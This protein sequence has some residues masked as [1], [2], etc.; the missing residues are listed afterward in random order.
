MI[1]RLLPALLLAALA[2]CAH[3][4]GL[5]LDAE[6]PYLSNLR[7]LTFSG[8][9]AEGYFGFA[10]RSFVYQRT[11]PDSG[12]IC[13]QIYSYDLETGRQRRISNGQGRTTCSYYLPGDTLV[14]YATTHFADP[15][16]P[17]RP[18]MSK[19]YVW[20]LYP[21]YDIVVADT[22]GRFVRRLT[23]SPGYDAEATVSPAGDRIVFTSTRT[24]DIELFSMNLDGSDVR[25]LTSSPGYDGG[26]FYSWDGKKIVFR[27]SMPTDSEMVAYRA[28]LAENLVRPSRMELFVMNADGSHRRQVTNNGAAN[29][30]PFW[31]P[32][33]RHII[34][35]SNVGDPEGR[36]FDLYLID[37]DGT[38]LRRITYNGT[39]DGFP[40]FTHDGRRLIFAS[41]RNDARPGE[42]NL[43]IGDFHMP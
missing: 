11:R 26:A 17:P 34:F 31:H 6:R 12:E 22:A 21:G 9:N 38:G 13:D 32:D 4:D 39:F 20:A 36:N 37:E 29:F 3:R 43:F 41:N 25:Q 35:A 28:L 8:E 24:G 1:R 5:V 40:M 10:E 7:Q 16:C 15:A 19:G 14:L 30:A 42:T 33:G 2:G 23:S 18:D 27:A